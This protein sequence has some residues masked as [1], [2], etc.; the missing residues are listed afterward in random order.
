MVYYCTT[1]E[2]GYY[3]I[4]TVIDSLTISCNYFNKNNVLIEQQ[5]LLIDSEVQSICTIKSTNDC[6]TSCIVTKEWIG[7]TTITFSNAIDNNNNKKKIIPNWN[8]YNLS[9]TSTSLFVFPSTSILY[10]NSSKVFIVFVGFDTYFTTVNNSNSCC[11][12]SWSI[13][14]KLTIVSELGQI[15][16]LAT[17]RD[18]FSVVRALEIS[19]TNSTI[20]VIYKGEFM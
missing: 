10:L 4:S 19:S 18:T 6:F 2:S 15:S 12:N 9:Q 13:V 14:G 7:F 8:K 11:D 3:L 17:G 5:H 1:T 20:V 16:R